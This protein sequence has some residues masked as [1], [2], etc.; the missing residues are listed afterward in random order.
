MGLL[1][2]GCFDFVCSLLI[3]VEERWLLSVRFHIIQ[4]INVMLDMHIFILVSKIYHLAGLVPPLWH[5]GGLWDD[6]SRKDTL[7]SRL[8]FILISSGLRVPILKAFRH[9][10]PREV[11][12]QYWYPKAA[13]M[14][15]TTQYQN[16]PTVASPVAGE[17]TPNLVGRSGFE[18]CQTVAH[19]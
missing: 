13:S 17:P 11:S 6:P 12:A 3:W 16:T 9:P 8:E 5:L 7:G 14:Q 10:G 2:C 1:A 15:R 18:G 4:V 19:Q